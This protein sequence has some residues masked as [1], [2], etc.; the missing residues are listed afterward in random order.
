M[1]NKPLQFIIFTQFNQTLFRNHA[2]TRVCSIRFQARQNTSNLCKMK[3]LFIMQYNC[4]KGNIL[5]SR[6]IIVV[7]YTTNMESI[8]FYFFSKFNGYR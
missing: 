5:S 7:I 1:Q 6:L 2:Q 4:N 8:L 3:S